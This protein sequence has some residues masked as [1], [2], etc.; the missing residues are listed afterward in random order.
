MLTHKQVEQLLDVTSEVDARQQDAADV[1]RL[2]L[3]TGC[4]SGEILRLKWS[5]VHPV[6]LE[7]ETTKTG[8]RRVELSHAAQRIRARRQETRRSRYLVFPS[9]EDPSKPINSIDTAWHG[10]LRRAKIFGRCRLHDLRHTYASHALQSGETLHM[11]GKLLGHK[12]P[13][14]TERYA[15]LD[16]KYLS[17]AA[18]K[19]SS[20]IEQMMG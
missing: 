1:V 20:K 2:T 6:T 16:G 11:T 9:L 15:H 4:R 12:N 8:G 3:L 17:K 14:S 13:R 5:E 10:F 19:V 7:L 18:Q